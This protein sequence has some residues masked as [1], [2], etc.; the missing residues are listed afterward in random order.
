MHNTAES[1]W[2]TGLR[3]NLGQLGEEVTHGKLP[4]LV[5]VLAVGLKG[6]WAGSE[7]HSLKEV[8][9]PVIDDVHISMTYFLLGLQSKLVL[10]VD[11]TLS[12]QGDHQSFVQPYAYPLLVGMRCTPCRDNMFTLAEGACHTYGE[13][14]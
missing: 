13:V 8:L 5:S 12:F 4:V 11:A 14:S 2:S 9:A 7:S 1:F 10:V 3:S 6:H